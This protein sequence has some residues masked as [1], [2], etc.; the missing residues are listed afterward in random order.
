MKATDRQ[1]L[2]HNELAEALLQWWTQAKP[3]LSYVL[4]GVV[5]VA[6]AI[7]FVAHQDQQ[8]K[9]DEDKS[10]LAFLP[11]L[12]GP[13]TGEPIEQVSRQI[14]DLDGFIRSFP[15]SPLVVAARLSL[16]GRYYDRAILGWAEPATKTSPTFKN[17]FQEAKRRY[18]ELVARNDDLGL[19]AKFGLACVTAELGDDEAARAAAKAEAEKQFIA[20]AKDNPNTSIETRANER[21]KVL[22]QAKPLD[23][24][25]ET[26]VTPKA[27]A[28]PS[29]AAAVKV[30]ALPVKNGQAAGVPPA[31]K[32]SESK[33]PKTSND[34]KK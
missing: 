7:F 17:D 11:A 8:K 19:E 24:A 15:A 28:V 29:G 32:S 25:A 6:A 16:A 27:S 22:R 5:V 18:E 4:I 33:G 10:L 9:A 12:N 2:T 30:P 26:P 34:K 1:Q 23:F 3:Y 14:T 31:A 21:L 20:L 13:S